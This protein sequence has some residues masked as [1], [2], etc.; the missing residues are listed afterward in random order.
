MIVPSI[1][2]K[3][4]PCPVYST[5]VG[6]VVSYAIGH[7]DAWE[8]PEAVFSPALWSPTPH[9]PRP[10]HVTQ[11][12]GTRT[13]LHHPTPYHAMST[14]ASPPPE[15]AHLLL[16]TT[17]GRR[18][19]RPANG[20]G[21]EVARALPNVPVHDC[22]WVGREEHL[23]APKQPKSWPH[24]AAPCFAWTHKVCAL[25]RELGHAPK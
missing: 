9:H 22:P 19:S 10:Y 13:S 6:R 7:S 4:H 8:A 21:R 15:A 18:L 17:R 23:A 24:L 20:D 16:V 3:A 12:D 11:H 25:Q 2:D 1:Y 14:L 5:Q